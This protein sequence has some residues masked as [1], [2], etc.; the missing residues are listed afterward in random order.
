MLNRPTFGGHIKGLGGFLGL[1]RTEAEITGVSYSLGRPTD[2][3]RI[4]SV[5]SSICELRV[6]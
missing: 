1:G 3:R 4:I 5:D 2:S 6:F